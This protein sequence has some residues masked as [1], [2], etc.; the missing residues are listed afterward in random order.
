MTA[1]KLP[2]I[3]W[4][5]I[6]QLR[7]KLT[8]HSDNEKL[9]AKYII[10][11]WQ[12]VTNK[13]ATIGATFGLISIYVPFLIIGVV[14]PFA[15]EAVKIYGETNTEIVQNLNTDGEY[16]QTE[17]R[18][19]HGKK[20][21]EAPIN[22]DGL[23]HGISTSWHLQSIHKSK[24]GEWKDGYWHGEWKFY[25]K[26]GKVESIVEYEMGQA[27]NYKVMESGILKKLPKDKWPFAMEKITQSTPEGP[28]TK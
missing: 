10:N 13:P 6:S 2:I 24:E 12:R 1:S 26:E 16:V 20:I 8:I 14:S 19:Y 9:V 11:I 23:Y 4:T 22:K 25:D 7:K 15:F 17:I 27:V 18:T 5:L 28:K 3:G 21:F